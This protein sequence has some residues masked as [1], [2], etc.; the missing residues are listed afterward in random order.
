MASESTTRSVDVQQLISGAARLELKALIA[1][2][3]CWQ[4]WISQAAKLSNIASDTLNAL[5]EDKASLSDTARRLTEFGKDN[6]EVFTALSSRL[7]KTYFDELGRLTD[8]INV[9]P[10]P[11]SGPSRPVA[12]AM[13]VTTGKPRRK[14]ARRK[15]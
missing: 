8:A 2:V 9:K 14:K 7:G 3:E 10:D 5:Q 4:T 15:A 6:T 13:N 12:P 1:G 11:A